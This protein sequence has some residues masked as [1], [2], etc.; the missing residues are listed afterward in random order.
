MRS[1]ANAED[2]PDLSFAGQQDTYLNIRGSD[3]VFEAVRDCWAS[4]WTA[5]ALSYRHEHAIAQ[6]AVAMAV[7][8]QMMVPSEVSGILFTANPAT[9]ERSEM[10][11]NASFGLGEAIVG[12]EITPDTYII[13]RDTLAVRETIIGGKEHMLVA[14]A[15]QGTDTRE[16][17]AAEREQSSLA[18]PVLRE[19][20]QLAIDVERH[21]D[22]P[23]DIEWAVVNGT[24]SLLQSR[25]IT[26]LPPAPLQKAAP[27]KGFSS[28]QFLS[29]L[30]SLSMEAQDE[31]ADI[32]ALI[33]GDEGLFELVLTTPA[34]RLLPAL[35]EL[36]GAQLIVQAIDQYLQRHGHQITTLDFAEPTLVED[37]L[38]VML[39]LKA[40]VQH[41]IHDP[42]ATQ[43]DI[44]RRRQ[45][46]LQLTR[47]GEIVRCPWHGW[48]FDI[49]NGRS[50]FNPHRLRVR[51]YPV[52][53]GSSGTPCSRCRRSASS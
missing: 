22:Q 5:R 16:L 24:L 4:L 52:T 41:T 14:A 2:L 3:A 15:G 38:P 25:P 39:N 11:V 46:R 42:A 20:A 1:S 40:V 6:E 26:N 7:V 30:R 13:D 44:A 53:I 8:V 48:E 49:T 12:G 31:I 33:R 23:Q 32:A 50:V 9:G 17:S 34:Q 29:G 36:T 21:F 35:R 37:P 28:G 51:S 19:L 27:G 18:E 47:E 10:I 45:K 43:I